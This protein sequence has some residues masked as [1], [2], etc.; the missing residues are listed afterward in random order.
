MANL[1]R[2]SKSLA[3]VQRLTCIVIVEPFFPTK[4]FCFAKPSTCDE[5]RPNDSMS[6]SIGF[7]DLI[8]TLKTNNIYIF[9]NSS[10]K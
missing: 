4:P 2:V 3:E 8:L 5:L 6:H 9:F 7:H 10:I 1:M